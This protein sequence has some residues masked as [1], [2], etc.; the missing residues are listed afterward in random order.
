M[1]NKC[2]K[3]EA[4]ASQFIDSFCATFGSLNS[5][6]AKFLIKQLSGSD[7]MSSSRIPKNSFYRLFRNGIEKG[8]VEFMMSTDMSVDGAG[9]LNLFL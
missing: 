7:E 4:P 8:F 9:L 1:C 6:K 5:E 3:E 2:Q